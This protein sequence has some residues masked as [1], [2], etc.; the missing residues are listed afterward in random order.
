MSQSP[1]REE[2]PLHR[3]PA[4]LGEL[5]PRAARWA[6]AFA[7]AATV[8]F[9]LWALV[10]HFAQPSDEAQRVG[11]LSHWGT[12]LL[13]FFLVAFT[14]VFLVRWIFLHRVLAD[15]AF[16][17]LGLVA[18]S[19][20]IL[21]LVIFFWSLVSNAVAWFYWTPKF[22][23]RNNEKLRREIAEASNL[24]EFTRKRMANVFEERDA[25]LLKAGNDEKKRAE[26]LTRFNKL[27][28]PYKRKLLEQQA[29]E[30]REHHSRY[31]REDTSPTALLWHFVTSG[32]SGNPQD[33]GVWY[34]LLGSLWVTAITIIV[35]L[36][37]GVGAA[38]YLEEYAPQRRNHLLTYL[39]QVN[40]NN[41]AGVP[42]VVYGVLGAGVFVYMIFRYVHLHV[43]SDIDAR[44]LLGGGLTLGLLTL[45]I[46]IVSAQEAI[47]AVPRS[48]RDGAYALGAT[49]WQV[50][51]RNVLP[52]ATPGILTGSILSISR[53]IGEAA[54]LVLFGALLYVD[55]EPTLFS[56]FTV[57][58]LQIFAWADRPYL[59][60]DGV[61]VPMWQYNSALA[62][63]LLL[64]CLLLL[65]AIAILL[66]NRA[67]QSLREQRT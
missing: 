49:Q 52:M 16:T 58:P 53:A 67:Q 39:I 48:I 50:I 17:A 36:P 22:I 3:P 23:E 10:I 26:V 37:I 8:V 40:I 62:S 56:R 14:S 54:P 18:T 32:P 25:E 47:R 30:I 20:G 13:G 11:Y 1:A 33:A 12:T 41:L 34:A 38:L 44:N 60:L 15:R 7:A 57:L 9:A 42:S 4:T 5:W 43:N 6:L 64:A 2:N 28:I 31:I 27:I 55:Q 66:R 63:L 29:R 46:I 61:P 19:F 35:A 45:P 59:T 51:W 24:D 21:M 65:N